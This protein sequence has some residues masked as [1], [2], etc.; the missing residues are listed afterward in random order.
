M[1][2]LLS[3]VLAAAPEA[4]VRVMVVGLFHMSNPGHDLHNLKA[5]DVL[6]PARQA[7]IEAV[8][9]ALAKFKP[10]RVAVEWPAD[11]VKERYAK[12][13][14]GTLPPSRNEVVQLG[15][16][17]A[18]TAGKPIDGIDVDG[19]FPYEDLDK[20]A[21]AH[22]QS[23][24]LDAQHAIVEE[25]MQKLQRTLADRGISAALRLLNDPEKVKSDNGFYRTTLRIGSGSTQPGVNLLTAWYK[26]NFQICANLIQL[27]QPGDRIVVFYG[28]G[29]AFLLRQCAA[30][31][32]GLELVEPNE[33]LSK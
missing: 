19:D 4:P 21:K 27:S 33:F 31:T 20:Y 29:H 22:G 12:Y 10:T 5:D 11:L 15:F 3:L 28:S 23:A 25:D 1:F 17:L 6:A 16:R 13:L 32:P 2:L 7:E 26:R 9:A 24:L 18:K 8:N 14:A 30:E